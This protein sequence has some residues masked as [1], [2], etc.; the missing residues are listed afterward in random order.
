MV[1]QQKRRLHETAEA[2]HHVVM[3]L[4]CALSFTEV[5]R[6]DLRVNTL[7][8]GFTPLQV[9]GKGEATGGVGH[10]CTK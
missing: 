9:E 6:G 1:S 7:V 5:N 2:D 4:F 10:P 8:V 3:K